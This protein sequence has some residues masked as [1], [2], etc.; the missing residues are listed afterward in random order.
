MPISDL[1]AK[2]NEYRDKRDNLNK[3]TKEYIKDLQ[4]IEAKINEF[5]KLAKEK[6][7]KKRDLWNERVQKLKDKKIE[8]KN[9]LSDLYSE[10]NAQKK[11]NKND[12]DYH[13]IKGIERKIEALERRIETENLDIKEENEIVDQ[14]RE[15]T[16]EKKKIKDRQKEDDS[17]KL[18]RKIEI[19]KLNL[20][21][22]Y[23]KL[24]KWSNKSQENHQKMHEIY[25]NVS[26]LREKKNK[27]EEELIQ[28]KKLA[29]DYHEKFVEAMHAKRKRT[30]G[31]KNYPSK[32]RRSS[33][34]RR[35]GGHKRWNKRQAEMEKI[36]QNKLEKAL[37]KQKAGK[38][39]N[40]FEARLILEKGD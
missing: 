21:K 13:S 14:I 22:I 39:L 36:K 23:E 29:D 24:D 19:C 37:E 25:D 18:D 26:E 12:Q 3:K 4:E 9:L 33:Q 11:G 34:R 40:I 10:K 28:N 38:K 17:Y 2:V 6:Y 30:K 8:Y 5:L 32:K 1:Q 15:L 35:G 31:K 20:D 27:L 7:K 16:G